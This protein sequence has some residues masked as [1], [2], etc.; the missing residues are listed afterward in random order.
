MAIRALLFDLDDTL[1]ETHHAHA[2]SLRICCEAVAS[3]H[4]GRS[5]EALREAFTRIYRCLEARAE[6]GEI[7]FSSQALFRTHVWEETLKESGL[8]LALGEEMAEVYRSERRR[9]FAVYDDVPPVLERLAG[10]YRLV[11]VTNGLGDV[12]R[13]KVEAVGLDHWIKRLAISGELRSWKPDAGIFRHAL[14]LADAEPQE[15]VMVGDSL[16]R[17]VRG[18]QALGIRGV[19]VRRYDH[20]HPDD[21]IAPDAT[22]GDLRTLRETVGGWS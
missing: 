18:A 14:A 7:E 3:R 20:L 11:L 5:V 17:D 8:P 10:E 2:A 19:W 6:A 21:G 4:P 22:L 9:R 15:A 12:Q 13:E 16:Q 1:I